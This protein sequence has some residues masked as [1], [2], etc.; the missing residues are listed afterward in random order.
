MYIFLIHLSVCDV[1]FTTNIAPEMLYHILSEVGKVS[2]AGCISQFYV[3]GSSTVAESFILTAMSYDRYLAICNPLRYT[4][5]MEHRV[6]L[7][8]VGASWLVGLLVTLSTSLMVFTNNFCGPNIIDHFICEL[9][10]LLK[11]S[12]SNTS[13]SETLI[14]ILSIPII[15]IPFVFIIV[16]YM[17]IFLTVLKIPF[18]TGRWKTFSTCS[19]HLTSVS[20]Y[21]G[22]LT[23]I[24]VVPKRG[25][26]LSKALY[27]LYTVITPL[28]NPIIYSLR[29]QDMRKAFERLLNK[30]K[31]NQS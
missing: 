29:N 30:K 19:S 15:I 23:A 16:S 5:I 20:T 1:V 22:T 9:D 24:Y 13:L 31:I 17:C 21:Y 25:R 7:K 8:F 11:L 27:V 6:C 4:S 2:M 3:Y 10:P 12:C 14:F 18:S 28:F 26:A